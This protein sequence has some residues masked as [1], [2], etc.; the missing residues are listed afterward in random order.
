M[1]VTSHSGHIYG[2]YEFVVSY[3]DHG[4][5]PCMCLVP[6]TA[7]SVTNYYSTASP[8]M[9]MCG[10]DGHEAFSVGRIGALAFSFPDPL[11]MRPRP[12]SHEGVAAVS[13]CSSATHARR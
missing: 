11:W 1:R 5:L 3:Y 6:I 4:A 9:T 10:R 7:P 12:V 13:G 2:I 8:M